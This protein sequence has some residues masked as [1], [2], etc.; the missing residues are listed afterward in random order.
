MTT[1][2]DS[3]LGVKKETTY[4]TYAVPDRHFEFTEEDLNHTFTYSEGN[5]QR[6]GK[7]MKSARRRVVTMVDV[8]GS[9][10]TELLTKG[11]G[12]LFEAALG[13][14]TST[15]IPTTAAYQQLFTPT[16][17]DLL[18]SYTIQKSIPLVGGGAAQP[19]S[20]LGMICSG[21]ELSVPNSGIPTLKTN[22]LGKDLSTAQTFASP[23]YPAQADLLSF[24]GGSIRIG[25]AVTPPTATALAVGGDEAA[26]ITEFN[27][28]YDNGLDTGGRFLGGDGKRGRKN[29]LG[30]R[31]VSGTLT[32][33]YDSNV[34]R[35]AYLNQTPLAL[36]LQFEHAVEIAAGHKPTIEITI[37]VISLE[38]DVPKVNGGA[39]VTQAIAFTALDGGV[40]AHPFYVAIVTAETA[41]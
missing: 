9:F 25:G 41:I 29:V 15:L 38:G 40:A 20:F 39:P 6:Y 7:R 31:S 23:S 17:T 24:V 10:S 4:G 27:L 21:F 19:H 22:W 36:V 12:V 28:T 33:E 13:T 35:D 2:L 8:A 37:P 30:E 34:L 26:N 3:A 1:Q 32:A 16:A 11:L 18:P 14:G 5:G